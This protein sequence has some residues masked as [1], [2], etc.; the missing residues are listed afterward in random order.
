MKYG[1]F[2]NTKFNIVYVDPMNAL[3]AEVV[4]NSSARLKEYNITVR[5][6][7]GD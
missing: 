3:V 7:S 6:L 1:E 4:G 5:D 2:D